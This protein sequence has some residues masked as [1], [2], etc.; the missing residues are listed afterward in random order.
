MASVNAH[1]GTMTLNLVKMMMMM[2]MQMLVV[3]SNRDNSDAKCH[4]KESSTAADIAGGDAVV[5]VP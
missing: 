4:S 5:A 1:T 3:D 2:M